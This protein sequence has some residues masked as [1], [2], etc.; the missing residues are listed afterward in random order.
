MK[1]HILTL[2]LALF[3]S[4]LL[5]A[6]AIAQSGDDVIDPVAL[7]AEPTTE[8][9]ATTEAGGDVV[10][11]VDAPEPAPAP[12]APPIDW[13]TII[14]GILAMV[15]VLNQYTNGGVVKT[16]AGIFKVSQEQAQEWYDRG[17]KAGIQQQLM[18]AMK[19]EDKADDAKAYQLA[20]DAGYK[21]IIL[22]DGTP[23][24]EKTPVAVPAG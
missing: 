12:V 23:V 16:V 7:T 4:V 2:L 9:V 6:P 24:L 22:S 13:Q 3:I 10:I 19:T 17:V 21:V 5:A 8:P 11:N 18:A 15:V 1:K 20:R 14:T